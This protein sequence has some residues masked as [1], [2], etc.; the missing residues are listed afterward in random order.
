V[1]DEGHGDIRLHCPICR[2]ELRR[3]KREHYVAERERWAS[4]TERIHRTLEEDASK[5]VDAD[6][7]TGSSEG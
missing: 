4:W 3:I 7:P 6:P 5:S 2:A 1:A